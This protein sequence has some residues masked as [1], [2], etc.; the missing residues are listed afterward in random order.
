MRVDALP[1]DPVA[2]T[3]T[4]LSFL[5]RHAERNAARSIVRTRVL[6]PTAAR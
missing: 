2:P 4:P 5:S 3:K 6:M 1:A